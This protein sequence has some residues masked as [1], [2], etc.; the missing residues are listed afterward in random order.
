MGYGS[1]IELTASK[2]LDKVSEEQIIE[3]Y[4]GIEINFNRLYTNP[5]RSTDERPGCKFYI[6]KDTGRIKFRDY[7]EQWDEDCFGIVMRIE[8]CNFPRALEKIAETF[9]IYDRKR[10]GLIPV[11]PS[12][13]KSL[14][15]IKDKTNITI[16][17][18][19][20]NKLDAKYWNSFHINKLDL[21]EANVMP[22]QLAWIVED[23]ARLI[24]EYK[25]DDPCYAYIFPDKTVKLYFPFREVGRFLGNSRYVQGYN[26]LPKRGTNLIITKSYKDVLCMK[27][28]GISAI[29]PQAEGILIDVELMIELKNRFDNIHSLYDWDRAGIKGALRMNKE[30]GIPYLFFTRSGL[31]KVKVDFGIKDFAENLSKFGIHDTIDIIE[32]TKAKLI[33]EEIEEEVPF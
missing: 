27:K 11:L 15:V 24:Y 17:P 30:Y 29:A 9:G 16:R 8:R 28:F 13:E 20:W 19:K 10:S 3:Y 14:R 1:T 18:R 4:L 12:K 21:E 6:S 33:K 5:L 26:L 22:I 32:Y 23:I 31:V 25:E 7:A 2:I